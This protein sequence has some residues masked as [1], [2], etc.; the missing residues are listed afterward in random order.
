MKRIAVFVAILLSA[1]GAGA[2]WVA[3]QEGRPGSSLPFS[4]A[5]EAG[6][7]LYVSGQIAISP[8][9]SEVRGSVA[10]ETRQVMANIGRTLR[11][12]GYDYDD[13]VRATVYLHDIG[14]YAEMNEA[15]AAFFTA[16]Y[17]ARACV[18]GVDIVRGFRVEI[19]VVAY[20]GE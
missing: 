10:A 9:G 15:Y 19:S 7:T 11:Q 3:A 6:D 5:R 12:H 18:G 16:P 20:R 4:P 1:V 2:F 17:P 13:V 8:D 14:D